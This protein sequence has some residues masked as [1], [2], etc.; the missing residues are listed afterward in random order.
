[1]QEM[2]SSS[3]SLKLNKDRLLFCF[4]VTCLL[5][6]MFQSKRLYF[7][8][9]IPTSL[10]SVMTVISCICIISHYR[11]NYR[12]VSTSEILFLCLVFLLYSYEFINVGELSLLSLL[13]H[14]NVAFIAAF[15]IMSKVEL[16]ERILKLVILS[17]QIIVAIYL[18]GWILYLLQ[19][20]LPHYF[21]QTDSFYSH[22][23]YYLF[24]VNQTSDIISIPRFAG[25]FLEPGHLGTMCCFLLH[26][27]GYKLSKIGNIVLLLGII[28]SLSLAAYGLLF[29]GFCL[30][31]LFT[32]KKGGLYICT[33]LLFVVGIWGISNN[34]NQGYNY[35]NQKIFL[36]LA[37]E[38]GEMA[39]SNRT[40]NFFELHFERYLKSSETLMGVGREAYDTKADT[41]IVN[42]C[43]GYK[44]FFYIRGWVGTLLLC[45]FLITYILKYKSNYTFPFFI[46][47]V[48]ANLIRDYPLKEFWFFLFI[49]AIPVM[50]SKKYMI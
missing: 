25:M 16:K 45:S 2:F 14:I 50:N 8:W 46:V 42:G 29:G 40:T 1:M 31:L 11:K 34:Y 26:I 23:V 47:F 17:T 19:F 49:L 3:W 30:H 12:Y 37:F 33:F 41:N 5:L 20:P 39:G 7:T 48:V 22:E 13:F 18:F 6:T 43:A 21:S 27:G 32:N 15:L 4:L 28:F 10:L 24:L 38:D 44:R 36:R 9:G 35:L